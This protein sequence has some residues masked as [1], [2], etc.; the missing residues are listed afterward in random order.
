MLGP[1]ARATLRVI[2]RAAAEAL[3]PS[4]ISAAD[5]VAALTESGLD[6]GPDPTATLVEA[7]LGRAAFVELSGRRWLALDRA[8]DGTRWAT[9]AHAGVAADDA[10]ATDPDLELIAICAL[11]RGMPYGGA[12]D[13]AEPETVF[14]EELDDG[15]DAL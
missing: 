15:R 12:V 6:L 10:L 4:A 7:L 9:I 3:G 13:G 1:M 11:E 2:R 14:F 8:L 5:L